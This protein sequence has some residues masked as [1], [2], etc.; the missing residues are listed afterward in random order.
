MAQGLVTLPESAPS[1]QAVAVFEHAGF[2]AGAGMSFVAAEG[3]G[4]HAA[5]GVVQLRSDDDAR[6]TLDYVRTQALKPQSFAVCSVNTREF[7]VA[8]IPGAK[9]VALTPQLDPPPDAP[10]PFVRYGI[11]FTIGSRLYLA[12]V[13][14]APGQVE[15]S[16]A[17]GT[18]RAL[19][20]RN[21]RSDA[22]L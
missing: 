3:Q 12:T 14:G 18:A 1:S 7:A 4:P 15:M 2:E 16:Q 6:K 13:D 5:V 19:Y 10:P 11:G 8:G 17:V 20:E 9:G 22:A 21:A